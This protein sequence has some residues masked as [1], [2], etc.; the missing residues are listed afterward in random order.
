M[1]QEWRRAGRHRLAAALPTQRDERETASPY[2]DPPQRANET[3]RQSHERFQLVY[4]A[5]YDVIWDWNLRTN[6]LWWSESLQTIFGYGAEEIEPN[7]ESWTGRIHPEDLDRVRT[8]IHAAIDSGQQSWSDQ[9]RFRRKDG[10]YAEVDDRGCIARQ[11]DGNPVR[12]IGAMHDISA[13]KRDEETIKRQRDEIASYYDNAPIGLAV[14]DPDLRYLRINKLLAEINGIPAAEHTGKTVKDLLPSFEAQAKKVISE[15][16]KT[17]KPIKDIEFSGETAA[18][19]GVIRFFLE[20]WYPL[21]NDANKTTGFTVIVQDITERKHMEE[22]L[23][24]QNKISDIFLSVH[25]DEMFNEVLKVILEVMQSPFGVFGYIDAAGALVVPTMTRQIWDKC[26][27]PEKTIIFPR[28]TWGDSS[29]PRA[30]REK[31]MIYT[32]E[33]SA[34]IPEGHV[35]IQRH[36]SLP[37]LFQGEVIGLFQVANKETDYTE[38]D[39]VKLETIAGF[40]APVLN[41]RLQRQRHEEELR[42]KNDDLTRFTYIVSHNLK[43]PLVTIRTF[44]GYLEK[45]ARKRYTEGVNKDLRYIRAATDKMSRLLDELLELLRIGCKVNPPVE[46]PLQVIVKE[47]LDLVAGRMAER[48]AKVEVTPEPI[49]LYGDRPRLVEVFQNLVDNA[50]KFMGDEPAPR[51]EIGV[52][53]TGGEI[54]LFVR[55]NGIGIDPKHRAKLFGLFEQLDPSMEGTG[56]GLALARRIVEV[57]GGRIWVESEGHGKGATFRFTLSKT[58]RQPS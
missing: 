25:D 42:K 9:Y 55:D 46:V 1:I 31:R 44:V 29:W 26:R 56:I 7:I 51:V 15:I 16:I 53:Q 32:N 36:I 10:R 6:T 57:H 18:K 45:D 24:I 34:G 11:A 58:R 8:G 17:G 37:I 28:E 14:L 43:S 23:V 47:A 3:L 5:T 30:I 4:R 2:S 12:M 38:A 39:I 19:P 52:E 48:G 22:T 20:S 41:A 54:V 27:V 33:P 21:K 50:V 35:D 49:L 13:R 40:V